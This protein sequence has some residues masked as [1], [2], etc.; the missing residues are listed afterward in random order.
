M[1]GIQH[2]EGVHEKLGNGQG[3][4]RLT[5]LDDLINVTYSKDVCDLFTKGTHHHNVSAVLITQNKF[6]QRRFCKNFSKRQI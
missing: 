2:H 6:Q 5:I 1:E 3:K 4:A